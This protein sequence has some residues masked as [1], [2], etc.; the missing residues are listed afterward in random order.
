MTAGFTPDDQDKLAA[1]L[2]LLIEDLV[3]ELHAGKPPGFVISLDSSLDDDLALDSLARVELISRIEKHFNVT[4]PQRDFAEAESPRELLRSIINAHGLKKA[5]PSRQ[6]IERAVGKIG[7]LP[8][9]LEWH[10][11]NNPE[12]L[13]INILGDDDEVQSLTYRQLWQGARQVAAGLQQSG[14]QAGEAVAIMLP[15]GRDYFFSFFGILLTGAVPVPIYPP[16]RRSQLEDHLQRHGGILNNCVATLLI[17]MPEAKVVARLLKSQVL[18]LREVVTLDDLRSVSAAYIRPSINPDDIAFLQY[19]SG[20]TGNPKGVVLTH[21]NLLA[22][23][24]AMGEAVAATPD[25]VFVSWLPLY[26]DMGL[27]GA[28]LGSMYFA[29]LLVV[30]SP[31]SF[32]SRPERWLW[33]I[34][35]YRGTL[36]AAPNFGFEFCLLRLDDEAIAGL[37]LSCWRLAFNGAEPVSAES[38]D[39][40]IQRF[41]AFGFK[42]EAMMPVYGLAES[43]VGLAFPPLNRKP[44]ID[45]IRRDDFSQSGH[46][47]PADPADINALHFVACGHALPGHQIRIVDIDG[48]ELPERQQG[49]LLFRGPSTT[50]GY[51]RNAQAT[52]SLF[53][54]DW[55]D[56]GD[57]AYLAD[58]DVFI[59]GRN[60]DLI[61]RAGRNVYPPE[62]EE[63]VGNLDGI[64]KGCVAA[65]AA[66]D[67]HYS[68]ER[69]VIL[70]ETRIT[71]QKIQQALKNEINE[72][73]RDLIGLPPDEV[74]L[75]PPHTV[76]KTSSGKIRRSACRELYEQNRL[77]QTARSFWLQVTRTVAKSALPQMRRLLHQF[78][79]GAYALY[80]WSLFLILTA[81]TWLSVMLLPTLKWRW[82]AA[83]ALARFLFFASGVKIIVNG[84]ENLPPESQVSVYVANHSSYLDSFAVVASIPRNFS[85][86]AKHELSR[87]FFTGAALK[88]VGTRFVERFDKRRSVQ[89]AR[90]IASTGYPTQSLFFYPEGTFTPVTGLRNFHMGAF[91]T[92]ATTGMQVVPIAIRGTR[93]M[94]RPGTWMPR[95]GQISFTV[96]EPITP[97]TKVKAV[98][99]NSWTVALNLREAAHRHIL[100]HCGEVDLSYRSSSA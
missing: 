26:H 3:T 30:M 6:V 17:T 34:H 11:Q 71:D 93:S 32:L 44:V 79:G 13:H 95:R 29:I 20:S 63:A 91:V 55:L 76:L 92:A 24:R 5:L 65:F 38:I 88:R 61:I 51:Y 66:R 99:E 46:A 1:T 2:L 33:A 90:D 56:S 19:T 98:P 70:A 82:R 23:I 100:A 89:D 41:Q 78:V 85:F 36:S 57:L 74:I 27:I 15:T 54:G 37:D 64:R 16:V 81:V 52:Q 68:T 45:R 77:G 59:T 28:W 67:R 87:N 4:L 49:S 22:N 69:L 31:L 18:S 58:G 86:V 53:V 94:L 97:D 80:V 62:V 83:H 50:S 21:N 8:E 48:K 75:A 43:S 9:V 47:I 10:V 35:Q 14:V 25:D 40:F 73:S 84:L 60:K 39:G 72:I 12:R 7:E 96:G 42:A